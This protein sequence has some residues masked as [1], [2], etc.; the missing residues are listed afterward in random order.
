MG[1]SRRVSNSSE[2]LSN[3]TT[4]L[5]ARLNDKIQMDTTSSTKLPRIF[6]VGGSVGCEEY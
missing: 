4:Q 2:R 5:E 1:E 6:L 3:S